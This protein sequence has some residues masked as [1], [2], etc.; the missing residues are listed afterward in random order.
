M[1]RPVVWALTRAREQTLIR[2][3][4]ADPARLS[5]DPTCWTYRSTGTLS[6]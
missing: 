6:A 4:T 5:F 3:V 2:A 1:M